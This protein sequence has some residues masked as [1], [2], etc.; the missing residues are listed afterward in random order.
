ME[1]PYPGRDRGKPGPIAQVDAPMTV[2]EH[3]GT[4]RVSGHVFP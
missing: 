1:A 4:I 3:T 2:I